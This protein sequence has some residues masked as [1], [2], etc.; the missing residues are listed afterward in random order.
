MAAA[1]GAAGGL[2]GVTGAGTET[3]WTV[4]AWAGVAEV[5]DGA[6]LTAGAGRAGGAM[7]SDALADPAALARGASVF[8]RVARTGRFTQKLRITATSPAKQSA[9]TAVK[10]PGTLILPVFCAG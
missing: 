10:I 9:I 1:A 6:V 7:D 4:E 5:A 8:T 3:R 2:D